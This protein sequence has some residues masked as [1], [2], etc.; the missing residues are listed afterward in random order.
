MRCAVFAVS[1]ALHG[2]GV[3]N[4]FLQVVRTQLC[5][6]CDLEGSRQVVEGMI[7]DL[8]G[9]SIRIHAYPP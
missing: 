2:T 1:H 5:V 8:L 6:T 3:Q 7:V 4:C 9:V